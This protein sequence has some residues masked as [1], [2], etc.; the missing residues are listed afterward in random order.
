[1]A[2]R[3]FDLA[4]RIGTMPLGPLSRKVAAIIPGGGV[5]ALVVFLLGQFG[6]RLPAEVNDAIGTVLAFATAY[7]VR[8]SAHVLGSLLASHPKATT[9]PKPKYASGGGA[10]PGNLP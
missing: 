9:T 10:K 6:V 4:R 2:R 5:G 3:L 1:M 7:A 8:E